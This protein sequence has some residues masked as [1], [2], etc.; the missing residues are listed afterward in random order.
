M[1]SLVF[2]TVIVDAVLEACCM[3]IGWHRSAR[4]L[5]AVF[6]AASASGRTS[7]WSWSRLR[8]CC[9]LTSRRQVS[10]PTLPTRWCISY[11][12]E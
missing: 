5:S 2:Y 3:L 8:E 12:G 7:R 11:R 6:P 4:S 10:M 9:F 1:K